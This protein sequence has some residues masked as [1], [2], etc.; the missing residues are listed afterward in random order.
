MKQYDVADG[1]GVLK[2]YLEHISDNRVLVAI[3]QKEWSFLLRYDIGTHDEVKHEYNEMLR[4]LCRRGLQYHLAQELADA[5][6]K[7]VNNEKT[8]YDNVIKW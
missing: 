2:V 5:I 1:T 4:S 6:N 8:P 7:A 3:P